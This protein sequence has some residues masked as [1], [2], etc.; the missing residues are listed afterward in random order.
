MS[1]YGRITRFRFPQAYQTCHDFTARGVRLLTDTGHHFAVMIEGG[2]YCCED[3][4]YALS[5]PAPLTTWIGKE[6][7]TVKWV[8]DQP[9]TITYSKLPTAV[10]HRSKLY[11]ATVELTFRDAP[12]LYVVLY[13]CRNPVPTVIKSS[14]CGMGSTIS[15]IFNA[16]PW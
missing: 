3:A 12:A 8:A 11:T 4:G 10:E 6:L 1:G 15:K 14:W 13:N 16:L 5:A 2:R 7:L 9:P